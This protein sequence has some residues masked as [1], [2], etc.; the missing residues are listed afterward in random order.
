MHEDDVQALCCREDIKLDI[1]GWEERESELV[2]KWR[3]NALLSLPWRPRLAA[4]GGTTHIFDQVLTQCQTSEAQQ[5]GSLL[6]S[7]L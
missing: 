1:T 4:S 7:V 3:F 5:G 6:A 2:T